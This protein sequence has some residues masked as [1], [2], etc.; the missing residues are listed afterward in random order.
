MRSIDLQRL[1]A[2]R[3]KHH[4]Q[5]CACNNQ[6]YR[7]K[8][9]CDDNQTLV[10]IWNP[11]ANVGSYPNTLHGGVQSLLIDE[12]MTCCLM[13]HDVI[14]VTADLRIRY[15]HPIVLTAPLEIRTHVTASNPPLYQVQTE[16]IQSG[17]R[18]V[19]ARGKFMPK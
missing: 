18:C 12:A 5:C 8:F 16:I 13:A 11:D 19:L 10:T 9:T 6:L 14:G 4:N 17:K 1:D 7:L 3:R 15:R 2:L